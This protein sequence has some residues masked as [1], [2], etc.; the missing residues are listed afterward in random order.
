MDNAISFAIL[1]PAFII[2]TTGLAVIM[3]RLP[4]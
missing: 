3:H 4:G 2:F 1:L